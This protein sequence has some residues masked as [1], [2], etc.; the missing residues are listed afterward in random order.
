MDEDQFVPKRGWFAQSENFQ[1][2]GGWSFTFG[3][4]KSPIQHCMDGYDKPITHAGFE[5]YFFLNVYG[6]QFTLGYN[7]VKPIKP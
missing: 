3:F 1:T 5:T 2:F 6:R 4:A 7:S